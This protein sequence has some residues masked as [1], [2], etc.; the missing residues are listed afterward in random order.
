[1]ADIAIIGGE[2]NGSSIAYHLVA[3]GRAGKVVVI[4]PDPTYEHAATPRSS[5]G[6]RR[7]F[8]IPEC[9]HMSQYGHEVYGNFDTL[10][11]INGEPP[12]SINFRRQGYMW[13]GTGS[14]HVDQLCENWKVHAANGVRTEVPGPKRREDA[15]SLAVGRRRG[16]RD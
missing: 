10:M 5:G 1:M 2:I 3:S 9:I 7:M 14:D 8:A 13:L 16:C 12:G 6:I 11:A 4:E 15:L